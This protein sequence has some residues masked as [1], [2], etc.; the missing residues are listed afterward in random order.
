M[1]PR[2]TP[3]TLR[4]GTLALCGAMCGAMLQRPGSAVS[5]AA[6]RSWSA[7]WRGAGVVLMLLG[8]A[9]YL[10][11]LL[12]IPPVDRDES[13][14]AQ[15]SRTMLE[16]GD[17]VVPRIQ[18]KPRLNKP[19]LIYWLQAGSARLLGDAP[20]SDGLGEW[21]NGNIWVYRLPSVLCAIGTVLLTW[22]LGLRM[23]DPRAAALAGALLAVCPMVVWDAH[24]ARADQLLLL[25]TTGAMHALFVCWKH[26]QRVAGAARPSVMWPLIFWAWMG[27]GILAK[28]PVTPII[29]ILTIITLS[30][31]SSS[32]RW[33]WSLR[34]LLGICVV[35]ALVGPWVWLV[36]R[37]VGWSNYWPIILKET[38]GRSTDAAESHWGPPGYHTLLLA[39]LFWPGSLLTLM[40][41]GRAF[42]RGFAAH[43]NATLAQAGWF[44]R[45]LNAIRAARPARASE[46]FLLAWVV[47]SWLLFEIIATKLPHYTMPLYPAIALLSARAVMAATA[48]SLPRVRSLGTR[49]GTAIWSGIGFFGLS[50][51][52]VLL[53][54]V[55]G[56][57]EHLPE[58]AP[59]LGLLYLLL[60]GGMTLL[61][62][63]AAARGRFL[64]A[65][66]IGVGAMASWC[67]IMLACIAP[68]S[69]DLWISPRLVQAV[70]ASSPDRTAPVALI[71]YQEDSAILMLRD[72][73]Q[74]VDPAQLTDWITLHPTGIICIQK[75]PNTANPPQIPASHARSGTINGYNYSVGKRITIEVYHP[76][77]HAR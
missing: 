36:T 43:S 60:L 14:F 76:R 21:G 74:R 35:A 16:T 57:R 8:L 29:A 20:G 62:V 13:R 63:R 42:R 44:V 64:L 33:W 37:E 59:W 18:G 69:R 31:T 30:I 71:G 9:V 50:L 52:M 19:P 41:I 32:F 5:G 11:G 51:A 26:S 23:F 70:N 39:V 17:F 45:G 72:R 47:P 54:A 15:A 48:G 61:G 67:W 25:T 49:I 55:G 7:C 77:E 2:R 58:S 40:S 3:P 56:I 68:A 22:R 66:V 73:A 27:L 38:I 53:A 1:S 75:A 24:Q 10:P 6:A 46:A 12:S 34:P 28:G 65:H 4:A